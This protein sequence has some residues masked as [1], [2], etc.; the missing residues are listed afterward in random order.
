MFNS[1]QITITIIT[2]CLS[3]AGYL[4]RSKLKK[5]DDSYEKLKIECD[6]K[7]NKR[8]LKELLSLYLEP[9]SIEIKNIQNTINK[10][11]VIKTRD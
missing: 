9:L 4:F 8:D 10:I 7:I 3:V 5:M 6:S 11:I 1:N 2:F